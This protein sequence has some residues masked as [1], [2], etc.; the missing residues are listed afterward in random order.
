MVTPRLRPYT[1]LHLFLQKVRMLFDSVLFRGHR[2]HGKTLK[3]HGGP[4]SFGLFDSDECLWEGGSWIE[5]HSMP[6]IHDVG[7]NEPHMRTDQHILGSHVLA[8]L[9]EP[10]ESWN[11]RKCNT[12]YIPNQH[13]SLL[14]FWAGVF[15]DKRWWGQFL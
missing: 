5:P 10:Q 15:L 6:C 11:V 9:A 14:H 8:T 7:S 2:R 12:E 1:V 3:H 4:A 13:L